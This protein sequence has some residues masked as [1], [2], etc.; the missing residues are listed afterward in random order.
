MENKTEQYEI[1]KRVEDK[2]FYYNHFILTAFRTIERNVLWLE[3][4]TFTI[5][6]NGFPTKID[7]T[8]MSVYEFE[9]TIL[10]YGIE[11]K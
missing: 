4:R 7:I 10:K 1:F 11:L 6:E 3:V 9:D 8:E 5:D 2:H